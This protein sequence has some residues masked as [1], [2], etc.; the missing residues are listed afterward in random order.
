MEEL[1][2]ENPCRR[3]PEIDF[4]TFKYKFHIQTKDIVT[5]D[6]YVTDSTG[7]FNVEKSFLG[8]VLERMKTQQKNL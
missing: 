7:T 3:L 8:E 6:N 4:M 5:P 1:S 2:Y